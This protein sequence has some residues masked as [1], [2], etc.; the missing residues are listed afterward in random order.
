[1][2]TRG[3]L[4]RIHARRAD[5][6]EPVEAQPRRVGRTPAPVAVVGR[7]GAV[8]VGLFWRRHRPLLTGH[9][10]TSTPPASINALPG[11][12]IAEARVQRAWLNCWAGWACPTTTKTT[13]RRASG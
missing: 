1:M 7:C 3:G 4:R 11:R 12:H 5:E 6:P 9:G 10:S 13:R 8:S 2:H